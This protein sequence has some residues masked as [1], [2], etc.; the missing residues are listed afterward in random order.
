MAKI[1]LINSERTSRQILEHAFMLYEHEVV[2]TQHGDEGVTLAVT[3]SPDI[4]VMDMDAVGLNG[5]QVIKVLKESRTTWSIP[6]IAMA[7]PTITGQMLLQTGFDTYERKPVSARYVLQKIDALVDS[8]SSVKGLSQPNAP[9]SSS[10]GCAPTTSDDQYQLDHTTVAYVDNN[11]AD[12]QA[13]AKIVQG[14]GYNYVNISE[15]LQVLPQLIEHS[16]QLIFLELALPVVNGYELCAQIRRISSLK[17]TPII[18]V[19]N[20]D[21]IADRFRAKLVG[22]SDFLSKPIRVKPVLKVL[23]KYLSSRSTV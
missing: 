8:P 19:T 16:P 18:I 1:L 21:R 9:L 7:D 10:D 2:T 15:P 22:S 11:L 5:W 14:A 17:K 6:V 13:M 23:I 3:E 12:S 20:N 4:I